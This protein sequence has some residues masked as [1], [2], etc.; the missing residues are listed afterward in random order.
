VLRK[1]NQE[2]FKDLELNKEEHAEHIKAME[3]SADIAFNKQ[4]EELASMKA[5]L[6]E[7]RKHAC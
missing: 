1:K 5:N 4:R 2:L 6:E 3:E 7:A